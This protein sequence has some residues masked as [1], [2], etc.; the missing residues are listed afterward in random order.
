MMTDPTQP[1]RDAMILI[2]YDGSTDAQAA[3][4]DVARLM[5]GARATVLTVWVP[6]MDSLARTAS[7]GMGLGMLGSY[8][9]AESDG[10]DAANRAAALATATQGARRATVAGLVA[11]P[12]AQR[13]SGDVAGTIGEVAAEL[14]PELIA[15]GTRGLSGIKA[16]LLGSVS[17]AVVQHA[18]RPVLVVPTPATARRR[19]HRAGHD[20]A[21]A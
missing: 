6:F 3:I 20:S 19:S 16:L 15:L 9:Y 10:I 17:H 12:R 2:P 11:R 13:C 1:H 14:D 21:P 18:D 4:D 5:P 7:P 8:V